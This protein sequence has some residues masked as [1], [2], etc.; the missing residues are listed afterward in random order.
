MVY[1]H[2]FGFGLFGFWFS[3]FHSYA[4]DDLAMIKDSFIH[5]V[6]SGIVQCFIRLCLFFFPVRRWSQIPQV[7]SYQ[8]TTIP[9]NQS[10]GE[11]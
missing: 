7:N 11:T 10:I 4:T 9:I 2:V 1:L 8:K 3:F 6:A 5:H